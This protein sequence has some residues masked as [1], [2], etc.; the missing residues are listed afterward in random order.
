MAVTFNLLPDG[1][2]SLTLMPGLPADFRGPFLTG[3]DCTYGI[4]RSSQLVLQELRGEGYGVRFV[5]GRL[6]KSLHMT[7]WIHAEGLYSRL[8]YKG[9]T[10]SQSINPDGKYTREGQYCCFYAQPSDC[11]IIFEEEKE[12]SMLDLFYAPHLLSELVPYFPQLETEIKKGIPTFITPESYSMPVAIRESV[13]QLLNCPYD[14]NTRQFYFDLK[15]REIL[16]QILENIFRRDSAQ[17]SFT[18]WEVSRIQEV[19]EIL[20]QH[21]TTKPPSVRKLSRLVSLNEYKL[22]QGFRKYFSTSIG[23]W[24]YEQ[25]MQYSRELLLHTNKPI[26]EISRDVGYPLTTNFITAFR[27][28][29]GITPGELRRK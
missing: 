22:K 10:R 17:L 16:Y 12:C 3:A 4:S 14:V 25:K 26:K 29:F 20:K 18:P 13:N 9:G 6:L 1:T 7:G 23:K 8:V 15:I 28:R 21:I 2:Q 27:R 11:Q 5:I 19:A 24:M